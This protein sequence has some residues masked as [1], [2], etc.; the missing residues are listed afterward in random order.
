M[1]I[2][3]C[4]RACVRLFDILF[5]AEMRVCRIAKL[6]LRKFY[7]LKTTVALNSSR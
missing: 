2:Y 3:V 6:Y 7:L 1:K 5:I 4:V